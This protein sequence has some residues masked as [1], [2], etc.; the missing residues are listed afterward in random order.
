MITITRDKIYSSP[1]SLKKTNSN[2]KEVKEIQ[3]SDVIKFLGEEVEL[4]D[5]VTFK[6]LFDI[7]ILH[8]DFLNVLFSKEMRELMIDDFIFRIIR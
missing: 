7:I 2:S 8:K 5:D 4:G 6:N 1:F 3:A